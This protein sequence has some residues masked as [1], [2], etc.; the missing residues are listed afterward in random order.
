[1]KPNIHPP[2]YPNAKIKCDCG[3]EYT[4]GSTVKEMQVE[5]CAA[6]HPFYTGTQK[7][8]DTAGRIDK[9]KER[10][11]KKSKSQNPRSKISN[12]FDISHSAL[13]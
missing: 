1:M 10:L 4:I 6:C 9:F 2:F 7:L 5:I 12:N 11:K 13:I 3:T 8:I